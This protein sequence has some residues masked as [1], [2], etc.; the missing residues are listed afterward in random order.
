M[1][2]QVYFGTA[3]KQ[4]WIKSPASGMKASSVGWSTQSQLLD[5][6]AFVRRSNGT[7]RQY[8]ASWL[9]SM[10]NTD[11]SMSLHTIKDFAD[12]LYG[13]GPYYF[14]DPYAAKTNLMPPHWA[15][16]MLAEKGWL[17]LAT[18]VTPTYTAASVAN[19]FP[20]KYAE[21]ITTDDYESTEKLTIIIPTGYKLNFG[22]HGPLGGS[23]TGIRIVPYLRSTGL[24]DAALNPNM[25]TAGGTTRTNTQVNGT[26]Y[27]RVEIFI[28]TTLASTVRI[29][30][31]IA[32]LTLNGYSVDAG[33]FIA[34]RGITGLEFTQ[35]PAIDY[36]SANINNGQIG[37]SATW[38]EV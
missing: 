25:I 32:Q 13:D 38:V 9:G 19:N 12:G 36:Y 6:R 1:A 10:N 30:A 4:T 33:G 8:D 2:S 3:D 20:T 35:S 18:D 14:I 7:H 28:G 31:M 37:M 23:T 15:A 29:T 22:W 24:A 11:L 26:T 17:E 21:Y 27:S 16:P 5:G 34:G